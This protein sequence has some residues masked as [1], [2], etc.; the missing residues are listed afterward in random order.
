MKSQHEIYFAMQRVMNDFLFTDDS[1]KKISFIEVAKIL[2]RIGQEK[3]EPELIDMT[4][5]LCSMAK[6]QGSFLLNQ[7]P[8]KSKLV[9]NYVNKDDEPQA[10]FIE[11][12]KEQLFYF[13]LNFIAKE[14]I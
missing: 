4:N 6:G 7:H 13:F 5:S 14:T 3:V 11:N 1:V 8:N 10:K 9:A 2:S 12:T